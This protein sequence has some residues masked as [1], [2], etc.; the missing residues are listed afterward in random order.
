MLT[1]LV[2][3]LFG[4]RIAARRRN[5]SLSAPVD[6]L[7][8]RALLAVTFQFD[9]SLDTNNFFNTAAKRSAL[10][11]AGNVLSSHLGDTLDAIVPSGNNT[12]SANF[13]HPGTG[14]STTKTNLTIPANQYLIYAGGRDLGGSLG[15]GGWGGFGWS[16]SS[17]W[18]DTVT[19]RGEA[20]NGTDF[21]R[22]G[23][24]LSFNTNRDWHFGPT[25]EGLE[26]DEFDFFTVAFH[27]LVHSIGLSAGNAAFDRYVSGGTFR[28]PTAVAEYD[29]QGNVPLHSDGAHWALNT[30]DSGQPAVMDP[31][32]G[33]GVRELPTFLDWAVIDDIGWE[34]DRTVNDWGDAPSSKYP[35]LSSQNGARH[36]TK[37][38]LFLGGY[39][40]GESDGQSSD[41][42]DGFD[43]EDGVRFLETLFSGDDAR[44][45]VTA[46]REGKLNAWID[47]NLDGDWTDAGEQIIDDVDLEPGLNFLTI[48]VPASAVSGVSYARFRLNSS[49]NLSSVGAAADGEVEDYEVRVVDGVLAVDDTAQVNPGSSVNLNVIGN[50]IP[51]NRAEL[52]SF[53]APSKGTASQTGPGTIRFTAGGG[54]SGTAT[55]DY[56]VGLTQTKL[57]GTA[58]GAEL[59]RAMAV[60]GDTLVVGAP[61]DTTNAGASTGSVR[62]YRRS[63]F[64]WS[65]VQ[66]ITA[67]DEEAG[68]RF[69]FS[70]DLDGNTLVIGSRSDDDD[71]I[72]SGSV[73]VYKRDSETS[74]FSFSQ[75]LLASQGR[76]KDQFGFAV[77][78]ENNSLVVGIR[79]DDDKGKNSG[80]AEYF[81]RDGAGSDFAFQ[82]RIL[83]DTL[84]K[85]DQFGASIALSGNTLFIGARR[86]NN[87]KVNAG[88]V[89]VFGLSGT[90]WLVTKQILPSK[91]EDNGYFGLSL[92]VNGSRLAVG[93][94]ARDRQS[95]TGRVFIHEQN[96]GGGNNWGVTKRIDPQEANGGNR[97]GFSVAFSG[98][99]I[100][101]GAPRMVSDLG[102]AGEVRVYHRNSGG[103]DTWG[104]V[105]TVT[106]DDG[107]GGDELGYTTII[108]G[109]N[110]FSGARRDD[111][112]GL[113][114]GAVYFN[115]L[116]TDIGRV[117]ITI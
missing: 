62:V 54:D 22:W 74:N 49:G 73:Y 96:E 82:S 32:V 43:D 67:H 9:Y 84:E 91:P 50:D 17:S 33:A 68:D 7:E 20:Q 42:S 81:K 99:Q 39:G 29:G 65:L 15:R 27:E 110:L 98:N 21:A 41:D 70:V 38:G 71:G 94:P 1:D 111:G 100:S 6:A 89:Y 69:G 64:D 95:R 93:Q 12:W 36:G 60:F 79:Q 55:F 106:A 5:T 80:S 66:T 75:K 101:V 3:R 52:I 25:V 104:R 103:T 116:R 105:R 85:G 77:A 35:T 108:S 44:V 19:Y 13:T 63:G 30:T 83:P 14:N 10:T 31:S 97:F 26:N 87:A 86:D 28:G 112:G 76:E 34:V 117:T 45:E 115:D 40:D 88:S 92:A 58:A 78:L 8:E 51:S 23:G 16:G 61:L 18:G 4:P 59:G 11:L 24:T 2:L 107:G 57:S 47:F 109:D 90:D 46:N 113:N 72:N 48:D 53:T 37:A 114:S 56:T 102:N